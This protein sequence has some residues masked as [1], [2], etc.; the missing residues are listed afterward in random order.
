MKEEENSVKAEN[1][2]MHLQFTIISTKGMLYQHCFR[3]HK[4]LN[5]GLS[6]VKT[7]Y[8]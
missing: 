1:Y 3:I 4:A 8:W 5:I 2:F 7:R 6:V